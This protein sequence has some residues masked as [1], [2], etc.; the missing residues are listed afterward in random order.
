MMW[1]FGS[2]YIYTHTDI[3]YILYICVYVCIY[4]HVYIYIYIYLDNIYI[5]IFRYIFR[6]NNPYDLEGVCL[7]RQSSAEKSSDN[8]LPH[9]F[10]YVFKLNQFTAQYLKL[11]KSYFIK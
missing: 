1:F 6:Y 2:C 7:Q 9:K 11:L 4:V 3:Y 10:L 8:I 5:Y